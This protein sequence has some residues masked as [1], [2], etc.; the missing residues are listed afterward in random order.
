MLTVERAFPQTTCTAFAPAPTYAYV[1]LASAALSLLTAVLLG[2][3]N[4]AAASS[5]PAPVHALMSVTAETVARLADRTVRAC[6]MQFFLSLAVG[7]SLG[8][9]ETQP[10]CYLGTAGSMPGRNQPAA[11]QAAHPSS[12]ARCRLN[13]QAGAQRARKTPTKAAHDAAPVG[14]PPIPRR[15]SWSCNRLS[16]WQWHG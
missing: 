11:G 2:I 10:Q 4:T 1:Q 6:G 16:C 8:E 9:D 5:S 14:A 7:H 3:H 12:D 13:A 15:S